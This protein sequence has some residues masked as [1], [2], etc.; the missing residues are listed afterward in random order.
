[1]RFQDIVLGLAETKLSYWE[2][3]Y[4]KEDRANL[5]RIAKE[6][7][8]YYLVLDSTIFHP[9]SGGQ[10]S[11]TGVLIGEKFIFTVKKGFRV[12]NIVVLW[13]KSNG[14][15]KVGQVIQKIDWERRYLFMRRHAAAHLFDAALEQ[16][17]GEVC[18][19][20]DSWLGDNTFVGYK[21]N[22]PNRDEMDSII[23]F[24]SKCI[25]NNLSVTSKIVKRNEVN[26]KRSLWKRVLE[27]L[28]RIRLVQIDSF[29][30]VPCGGTHVEKLGEIRE[31]FIKDVKQEGEN[32]RVYYDVST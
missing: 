30:P 32:F 10:P 18:D 27:N 14:E 5:I 4:R 23:H 1:M 7:N 28:D 29:N 11:D 8:S 3:P 19:P 20:V 2:D 31:I 17:R 22:A 13:G 25:K 16:I 26:E 9:K 12:N 24:I 15:P 21:G 6:G